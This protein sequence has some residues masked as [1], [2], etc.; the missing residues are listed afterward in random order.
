MAGLNRKRGENTMKKF[1]LSLVV[2]LAAVFGSVSTSAAETNVNNSM[3]GKHYVTAKFISKEFGGEIGRYSNGRRFQGFQIDADLLPQE[4]MDFVDFIST[5]SYAQVGSTDKAWV[6]DVLISPVAYTSVS[7]H[8][9]LL[10][11]TMFGISKTRVKQ[12][13]DYK[14]TELIWGLNTGVELSQGRLSLLL[15]ID[16]WWMDE[17]GNGIEAGIESD[18]K[19]AEKVS[20][21]SSIAYEHNSDALAFAVGLRLCPFN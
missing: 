9:T 21:N 17:F 6:F 14:N 18:F 10:A 3:F 4:I 13:A 5:L 1:I 20:L 2:A 19:I 15:G 12:H 7:P 11:G 8:I 16:Y